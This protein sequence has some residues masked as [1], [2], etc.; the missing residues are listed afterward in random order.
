M[1]RMLRWTALRM[2]SAV[3]CGPGAQRS[4]LEWKKSKHGLKLVP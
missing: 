1:S 3:F 4:R 2:H